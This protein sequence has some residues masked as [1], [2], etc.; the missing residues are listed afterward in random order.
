MIDVRDEEMGAW[1]EARITKISPIN[2]ND[3]KLA[4]GLSSEHEPESSSGVETNGSSSASSSST[5]LLTD[6]EEDGFLYS[7]VFER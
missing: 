1:F 5:S 6:E 7:I 4:A 3:G 2:N